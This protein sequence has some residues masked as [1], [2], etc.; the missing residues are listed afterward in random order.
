VVARERGQRPHP[1]HDQGAAGRTVRTRRA[2]CAQAA[3]PPALPL[4]RA[5]R[6]TGAREGPPA[7]LGTPGHDRTTPAE[8]EYDRLAAWVS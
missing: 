4:A 5:A 7:R 8:A 6:R 3:R 2:P 1:R